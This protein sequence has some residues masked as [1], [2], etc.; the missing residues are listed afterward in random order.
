MSVQYCRPVNI[1][2]SSRS[3]V[4]LRKR[5]Y[6]KRIIVGNGRLK[7][8]GS[9]GDLILT[10]SQSGSRGHNLN[11]PLYQGS[12]CI[13]EVNRTNKCSLRGFQSVSE[14]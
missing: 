12:R 3:N 8:G 11:F 6:D 1:V 2:F 13:L 9:L 14:A 10:H 4:Q 5:L 7:M